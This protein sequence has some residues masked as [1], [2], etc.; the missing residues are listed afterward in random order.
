MEKYSS[1]LSTLAGD[2][3]F[4]Q[5][6]RGHKVSLIEHVVE[7]LGAKTSCGA[8]IDMCKCNQVSNACCMVIVNIGIVNGIATYVS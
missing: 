5:H 2:R 4:K 1:L 7:S 6:S 8:D 3:S